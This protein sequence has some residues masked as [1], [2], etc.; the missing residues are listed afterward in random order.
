MEILRVPPY[1]TD[2]V[3]TVGAPAGVYEYSI[4]DMADNSVSTGEVLSDNNSKVTIELPS[5]YDG[6]YLIN[7]DDEEH[8]FE[9]V[10]PYVDPNT[11]GK[12]AS[13]IAEYANHEELARAIIDSIVEDGFYYRKKLIQLTGLGADYL[14]L[15]DRC[16]KLLKLKENGLEVYNSESETQQEITYGLSE[17][18]T[19]ITIFYSGGINKAEGAPSILPSSRSDLLDIVYG[20]RGFPTGYDYVA[21]LEVGYKSIPSDIVRATELLIEDIACGKLEYY[22]R[23]VAD[24][25]TDQFKIKFDAAIFGPNGTG[26]LLVDKILSKYRNDIDLIGVL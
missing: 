24:Y 22:K 1:Q 9:V 12:T 8:F 21:T 14:P 17:D 2:A 23:Y 26:N 25:N 18:K 19:A 20:Y 13:E 5:K 3:I 11:K 10:R 16:Q 4:T 15:W 6:T 7:I